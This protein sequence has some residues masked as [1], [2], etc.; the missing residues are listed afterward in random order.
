M[1]A[2]IVARGMM[3][4]GLRDS[5]PYIAVDSKPIQDQKQKNR[6]SPADGPLKA[7]SGPS[8]GLGP[9]FCFWSWIGF[10]STAMYGEESRNPKRIIPRATIL[11]VI[12][13]GAL[14]TFVAWMTL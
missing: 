4:L 11:A 5:S 12:G 13:L 14:Y 9:F 8:A 10:E 1:T 2:R 3:R 7:F 6:P